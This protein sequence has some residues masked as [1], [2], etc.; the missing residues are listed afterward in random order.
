MITSMPEVAAHVY[1]ALVYLCPPAFRRAF[2][3]E[4]ARDFEDATCEA[5]RE[6]RWLAVVPLWMHLCHDLAWTVAAQWFRRGFPVVTVLAASS[7]AMCL[8]AVARLLSGPFQL[9][10]PAPNDEDEAV[11]L[12]LA[13]LVILLA[14]A[15]ILLTVCFLS[16]RLRRDRRVRRV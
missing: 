7:M 4:M 12:F 3:S 9:L 5:W 14:A 16:P 15:V 11:L 8:W 10:A 13:T 6:G 2:K 1:K